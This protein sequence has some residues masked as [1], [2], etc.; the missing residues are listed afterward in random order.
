VLVLAGRDETDGMFFSSAGNDSC[1]S[2]G[3]ALT[4]GN[5]SCEL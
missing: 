4:T 1:E 2:D 3:K 5:D